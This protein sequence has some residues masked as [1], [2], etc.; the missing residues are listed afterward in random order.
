MAKNRITVFKSIMVK[1]S[2]LKKSQELLGKPV[3]KISKIVS[4]SNVK[5][6]EL[7]PKISKKRKRKE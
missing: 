7:F 4:L 3:K 5:L 6:R 2:P 1:G